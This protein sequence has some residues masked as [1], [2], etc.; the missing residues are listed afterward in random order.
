M[1]L[2]LEKLFDSYNFSLKDRHEF[3]QIFSL[4]PSNKKVT[5]LENFPK[6]AAEIGLLREDLVFQQEVLF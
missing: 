6:I 4:L 2:Q 5:A 3:L 1:N